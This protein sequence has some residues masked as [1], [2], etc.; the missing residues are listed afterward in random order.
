M[1]LVTC[2][3]TFVGLLWGATAPASADSVYVY[4]ILNVPGAAET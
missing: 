4:D 3:L 1:R 2:T